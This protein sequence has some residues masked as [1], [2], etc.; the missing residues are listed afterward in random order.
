MYE[1]LTYSNGG[2]FTSKGQWLHPE[3]VI[4][5]VELIFVL[6]GEVNMFVGED[7]Y[8]L[9]HPS[10]LRIMP[11]ERHG[12]TE[13][14]SNV[15]FLWLHFN[16]A[17]S[18]ELPE[19]VS[20]P[21]NPER[22][23]SLIKELFHYSLT[24]GYPRECS[25]ALV[26]VILAE[27]THRSEQASGES[28]RLISEVREYIRCNRDLA[29]KSRD[30]ALHFKYNEDYISRVFKSHLGKSLKQYIDEERIESIKQDLTLSSLTLME[31]A[32][33]YSFS[34]YKYFLKYFK[35]H[36]GTTPSAYRE[37]YYNMKTNK[38]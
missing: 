29:L 13:P 33:R 10:V 37:L 24:K 35:Y 17:R 2:K 31:I 27:L 18:E 15:S 8:T 25:N 26:S 4:D 3:R 1:G 21:E 32:D 38:R 34:E 11:G 9:T 23:A 36:T 12:G 5:T 7:S 16:G 14:S 30:V 20:V 22:L 6:S 28:G 19:R